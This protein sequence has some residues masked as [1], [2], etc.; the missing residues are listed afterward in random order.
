[1]KEVILSA[2]RNGRPT[3]GTDFC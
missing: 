1:M 2:Q 3:P